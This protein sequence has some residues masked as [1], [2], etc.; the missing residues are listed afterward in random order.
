MTSTTAGAALQPP[1]VVV[2]FDID[3]TLEVG[4]PRGA[5]PIAFVRHLVS[6]DHH[7]VGSCSDNTVG[8]QQ[9]M[10]DAH[11]VSPHFT[12]VKHRLHQVRASFAATRYVHIGDRPS[13][14]EAAV[15]GGF[16]FIDVETLVG[17][18]GRF[19]VDLLMRTVLG[20]SL[21]AK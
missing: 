3:G 18:D 11:D 9:R 15:L 12:V 14:R 20:A 19:E 4:D 8:W 21:T 2:S 1:M 7:R 5:I 10:W 16:E 6:L 17:A 13:D